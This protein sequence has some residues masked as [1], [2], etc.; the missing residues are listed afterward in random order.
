M[1]NDVDLHEN[2]LEELVMDPRVEAGDVAIGVRDG[3]VTLTGTVA[4][5]MQKWDVEAA[6][7]RVRGVRAIANDIDVE[8]A[9]VHERTDADIARAVEE[10]LASSVYGLGNL[11]VVV[12]GG[13]V[14]LSGEVAWQHQRDEAV[15]EALRVLGVRNIT[16]TISVKN[17]FATA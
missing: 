14:A 10:R 8:V 11:Q 16:T 17:A 3:V 9:G 13:E 4:N 2:V 5:L 6:V 15:F 7:K 1:M 12:Q